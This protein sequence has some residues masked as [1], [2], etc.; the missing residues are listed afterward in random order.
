MKS[1]HISRLQPIDGTNESMPV[2]SAKHVPRLNGARKARCSIPDYSGFCVQTV[3]WLVTGVALSIQ[4]TC[5]AQPDPSWKIHDTSRPRPPVI[6]PGTPST[7]E[8]PG[9]PPSDATVLFN[10]KD[11]SQWCSMDGSAPKWIVRDG[12]FECVKGSGYVRTLQNFGDCQLHVEW[13]APMP[14]KGQGQGRGN[15]GVF[16]MGLYEVQ[17]LDSYQSATYADG[18]AGAIYAQH[19][20]LANASL[21]PGQ[22]QTYDIIFTRPHFTENGEL[23]SSARLTVLH[24]GVLIQN[25]A[26]LSGPTG[27]MRRAP[28]RAHQDKLPLSLQD[29]GN[30]VRYRNIWIRELTNPNQKEFTYSTNVL[31][32]YVGSYRSGT[33]LTITIAR[34][35]SQLTARLHTPDRDNTFAL[36]A[37]S[38][39]AFFI[40]S[41]DARCAFQTNAIGNSDALT[42]YIGGE[43]REAK[44]LP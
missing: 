1:D 32:H 40:K 31:D 30:P 25:N 13:A 35:D 8:Q 11:A 19:P 29:H 27:W 39:T 5:L 15:S 33:D 42:F 28:Y 12:G 17:V 34:A 26:A 41:V 20:P 9:K 36:F 6:E 21:P 22:W 10:G 37:E 4:M 44:R 16:L 3:G 18:G 7:P 24:N 2:S 14:A 23:V 38:P 43:K